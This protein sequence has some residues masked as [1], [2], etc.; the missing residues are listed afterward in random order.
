MQLARVPRS[1]TYRTA[2]LVTLP[3]PIAVRLSARSGSSVRRVL[4]VL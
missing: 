4:T 1:V 2:T 3:K